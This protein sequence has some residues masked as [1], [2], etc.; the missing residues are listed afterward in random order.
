MSQA[1]IDLN[2][3]RAGFLDLGRPQRTERDAAIDERV[4]VGN[5]GADRATFQNHRSDGSSLLLG[6]KMLSTS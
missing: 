2:C 5:C 3:M 1:S 4:A 6:L